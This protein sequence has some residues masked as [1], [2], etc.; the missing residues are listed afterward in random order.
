[1]KH[2]HFLII[3]IFLIK[4]GY[5]QMQVI[6]Q[7]LS[8]IGYVVTSQNCARIRKESHSSQRPVAIKVVIHPYSLCIC[9]H[10]CSVMLHCFSFEGE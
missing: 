1:H 7:L 9:L 8:T 5:F 2:L 4:K 6:S 10:N 3:S